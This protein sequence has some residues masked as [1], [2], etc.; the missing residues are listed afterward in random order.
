MSLNWIQNHVGGILNLNSEGN[1][2]A[3]MEHYYAEI[4]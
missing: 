3:K 1:Y 4:I 2:N